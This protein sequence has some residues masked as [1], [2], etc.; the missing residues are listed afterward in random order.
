MS[1]KDSKNLKPIYVGGGNMGATDEK[2]KLQFFA[3]LT[4]KI[5]ETNTQK[6]A[7]KETV[8]PCMYVRW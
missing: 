5:E 2:R 1:N 3:Q 4:H 7:L 8:L 6:Q